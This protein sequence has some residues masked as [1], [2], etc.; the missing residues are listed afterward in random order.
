MQIITDGAGRR[1]EKQGAMVAMSHG[2]QLP[3][4]HCKVQIQECPKVNSEGSRLFDI[5]LIYSRCSNLSHVYIV[6]AAPSLFLLVFVA[7]NM[8][9]LMLGGVLLLNFV[10]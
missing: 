1:Q 5:H 3:L 2:I 10:C 4:V 8:F 9:V 7:H 6:D